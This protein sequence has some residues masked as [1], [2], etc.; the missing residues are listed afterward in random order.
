[1]ACSLLNLGQKM[2]NEG[3]DSEPRKHGHYLVSLC[4]PSRFMHDY[5]LL[6]L[7]TA[8]RCIYAAFF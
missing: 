5:L 3:L 7:S 6:R 8:L 1:M 2:R 4:I